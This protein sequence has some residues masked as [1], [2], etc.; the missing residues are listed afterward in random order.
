LEKDPKFPWPHIALAQIYSLPKFRDNKKVDANLKS[1]LDTCPT[2]FDGYAELLRAD[3]DKAVIRKYASQ[4]RPVLEKREDTAAIAEYRT[5]WALEFKAASP[6][7]Y[8]GLRER[9]AR[10]VLRI[11]TLNLRENRDWYDVLEEGY[12]LANDHKNVDWVKNERELHVPGPW[13]PAFFGKWFEDHRA[14]NED[15]S[16]EIRHAY[17]KELLAQT[18]KWIQERPNS[19]AVW[20]KRLD[21]LTQL[22]EVPPKETEKTADQVIQVAQKNAGPGGPDSRVYV[23]VAK[24]LLK[25]HLQPG[26]VLK[27]A[28]KGLEASETEVKYFLQDFDSYLDKESLAELRC[29]FADSQLDGLSSR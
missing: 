26:R 28:Q 6:S 9:T 13:Y 29:Y 3:E 20:E 14:P 4:L 23:W 19:T 2:S 27:M 22:N 24:T 17:N 7:E 11:R 15:A 8:Q 18:N 1:F 25:K 16:E 10:D 12:T 5:L 21:A